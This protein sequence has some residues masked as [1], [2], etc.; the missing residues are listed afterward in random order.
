NHGV[1]PVATAVKRILLVGESANDLRQ[2]YG[3]WTALCRNEAAETLVR[4][5]S[6]AKN[7]TFL[8]AL[9]ARA[10]AAGADLEYVPA[11]GPAPTSP[12][13]NESDGIALAVARAKVA[14][15]V[16]AV[17]GD[18]D[19]WVGEG[20]DCARLELPG[21]QHALLEALHQ[22]C[23]SKGTPLVVVLA[24]SKPLAIPW[25]KAH[26]SAVVCV[27]NA[28]MGGGDALA[29]LLWGDRD[30]TG[31]TPI[32]WPAHVGQ[33]PVHYDRMPGLHFEGFSGGPQQAVPLANRD[34]MNAFGGDIHAWR[35]D[36]TRHI[37]LPSD[38]V[39]GLWPFGFGMS[40]ASIE[41]ENA[42]MSAER[43]ALGQAPS[44]KVE[45]HND[46][47][48]DGVAVIQVYVRDVV[49]SVTRPDRRLAAWKR[50]TVGA[51]ERTTTTIT[52][53]LE[54]LEV[55]DADGERVTEP[56]LFHALVGMSSRLSDLRVL[57]FSVDPK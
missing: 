22:V 24:T 19:H 18:S 47:T 25:V 43:W 20:R 56:G 33:L 39:N 53:A 54:L 32:S 42:A 17:V 9:R 26:A 41:I 4:A 38:W 28:G 13:V 16:L 34:A 50:V 10:E 48:R 44:L 27:W 55:I 57:P 30:F 3:C 6:E 31:R 21:R 1:L 5:H 49:A 23:V 46:G 40:Y 8:P 45:L 52:L 7:W 15:M 2:Q 35:Q 51:G 37:D 29:A 14:D 36:N 11:C 12:T